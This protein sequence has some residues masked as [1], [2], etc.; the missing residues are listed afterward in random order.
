[1]HGAFRGCEKSGILDC[2]WMSVLVWTSWRIKR[3]LPCV[4]R[5]LESV[6]ERGLLLAD[7]VCCFFKG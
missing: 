5:G 4:L 6:Y 1:M 3:H 7:I 2:D